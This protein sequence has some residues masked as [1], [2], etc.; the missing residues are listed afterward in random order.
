MGLLAI[1]YDLDNAWKTTLIH[2]WK[3]EVYIVCNIIIS[4]IISPSDSVD[5]IVYLVDAYYQAQP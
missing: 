4:S 2:M 3:D 1:L 5:A